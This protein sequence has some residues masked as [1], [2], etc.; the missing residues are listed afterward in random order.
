MGEEQKEKPGEG[1]AHLEFI[2]KS[3]AGAGVPGR[4][5]ALKCLRVPGKGAVQKDVFQAF[6]LD[7]RLDVILPENAVRAAAGE[8]GVKD[9]GTQGAG[10]VLSAVDGMEHSGVDK[11]TL[12]PGEKQALRAGVDLGGS[13]CDDQNFQILVPVPGHRRLDQILIVAGDWEKGG[14]VFGQLHPSGIGLQAAEREDCHKN[15][16]FWFPI[17][18]EIL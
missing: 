5:E 6:V 10:P 16:P 15:P 12:A 11:K 17:L 14:A 3:L 9:Q 4:P 13:F 18:A 2:T 7:K 8:P 1:G